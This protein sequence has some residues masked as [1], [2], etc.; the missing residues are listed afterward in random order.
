MQVISCF[1]P[2][3]VFAIFYFITYLAKKPCGGGGT[4]SKVVSQNAAMDHNEMISYS[5]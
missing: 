2:V 1:L 3:A 5:H 4:V